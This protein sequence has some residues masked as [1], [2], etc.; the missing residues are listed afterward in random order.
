MPT[1]ANRLRSRLEA[2]AVFLLRGVTGLLPLRW[3][4]VPGAAMGWVLFAV[5]RLARRTTLNNFATAFGN[6]PDAERLRL[7]GACYRFFGAVLWEFLNLPRIPRDRLGE[8]ITLADRDV[9][10]RALAEGRGVVLVSGHLGNWELMAGT[11]AA[12]GYPVSMYVGGQSNALV[13]GV[14]NAVR[15]SLGSETIGRGNLRGLLKALKA[16]RIV[17]LLA[18]QHESTKRWYV[19][20]F[21]QPVSAVSGPAQMLRRSGAVLVFG[22]CLR[23]GPFRYRTQ[24][25][26]LPVPPPAA[27]EERDV[28][29]VTQ[30]L[31]DALESVVKDHPEQ[32]FWLHRRFRPIPKTAR[33]TESNRAFLAEQGVHVPP[34]NVMKGAPGVQ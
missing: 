34:E 22:A 14:M 9:L 10:D 28:L 4:S 3:V 31:F 26:A 20:F 27:D 18:D 11:L 30:V 7:A 17:A 32:Y 15:R 16:R 23:E 1:P 5:L 33:L 13:D 21:G 24:F 12:E 8:F 2:L 19:R 6:R 29:N 25:R